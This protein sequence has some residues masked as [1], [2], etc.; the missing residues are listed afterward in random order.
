MGLM[1]AAKPAVDSI[2][3]A[4]EPSGRL[5]EA[6]RD[7]PIAKPDPES[8]LRPARAIYGSCIVEARSSALVYNFIVLD[9]SLQKQRRAESVEAYS[10]PSTRQPN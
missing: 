8:F 9:G 2:W 6:K 5:S 1:A 10:T 3:S 7:L 4:W